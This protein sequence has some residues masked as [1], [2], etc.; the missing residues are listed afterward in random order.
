MQDCVLRPKSPVLRRDVYKAKSMW[1]FVC[2][3]VQHLGREVTVLKEGPI[4]QVCD[5]R[6]GV[7]LQISL[8]N[9]TL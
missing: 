7:Y 8:N 1:H 5:C 3:R 4:F 2:I 6:V 9:Y